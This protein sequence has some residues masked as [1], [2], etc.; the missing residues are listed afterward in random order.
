MSEIL[1]LIEANKSQVLKDSELTRSI[2]LEILKQVYLR[3]MVEDPI[4]GTSFDCSVI[5]ALNN[6]IT[7][8]KE[9]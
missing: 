5:D 1:K 4:D 3:I 7:S 8:V 9:I 2:K 6:L